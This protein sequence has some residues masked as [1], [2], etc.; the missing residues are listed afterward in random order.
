M[1][2]VGAPSNAPT[3]RTWPAFSAA[4]WAGFVAGG[5]IALAALAAYRNSFAVPFIFDDIPTILRNGTIRHLG[6]LG[7][8]LS[9]P[10]DGGVGG[11]PLVNLSLALNYAGGGLAVGGYH[12][13]NLA[14]HTLAAFALFGV[15]RRTLLR[16]VL[17]A[18]FGAVAWPLA[19]AVAVL[20]A[21]HPLQ[22][23]SVTCVIQRTELLVG[24][25]YLLTFY[26]FVRAADSPRPGL[27][28]AL[29]IAAC[30]LGMASKEVMVTAPVLVF[31]YDRTF[32]AGSFRQAWQQRRSWYAGLA[33][34]WLL[35]GYLLTTTGG[36]RGSAVG[37]G[38]GVTWWEYA[39]TQCWAVVRYLQLS[40][41]P[42]PLIVDYGAAAVKQ[43]LTVWPQAVLLALLV[44]GTVVSLRRRPTLGFLG[45]W[46]FVILSPSSSVV[47]LVTQTIAEHRMYL[48]LVAVLVLTVVALFTWLGRR[49]L[50]VAA[51]L[52]VGLGVLT[53]QRNDTY[54]SWLTL[55]SDT[56]ARRPDNPRARLGLGDA[57]IKERRVPEAIVQYEEA[58]RLM[59]DYT[60]AH[61]NLGATLLQAGRVPEAMGQFAAALRIAPTD[62]E[63]NYNLGAALA[64]LGR[65]P[66]AAG[67]LEQ[68]V[69]LRP[70]YAEAHNNLGNAL[71]HLGRTREAADHYEQSL[72]LKPDDVDAH[73]N[74][75]NALYALGRLPEAIDQYRQALQLAPDADACCMLGN[76]LDRIG[77]PTEAIAQYEAALRLQP[78]H[79]QA[80]ANLARLRALPQ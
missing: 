26:C 72:R 42:H 34:T 36:N 4:R 57:L 56:V 29:T 68:A 16:P 78:D 25:F 11:R 37:F 7:A 12:A 64:R 49:S 3:E 52:A 45:A 27:W 19:L 65:M 17:R 15:V 35:L 40:F 80:R 76:A 44:A 61:N 55:W 43:V 2:A 50:L 73:Y 75:G 62:A 24:L 32:V 31:L 33:A 63:A 10:S 79:A 21:V 6:S 14:L 41:W 66:E 46:F 69:R 20:W 5:I 53:V 47:P 1:A 67:Y 60:Q 54:R 58:L 28:R 38:L 70:D 9:P 71:L 59:P 39:L 48:P 74:L 18:R 13:T 8:V 22:T 51:A 30:L 23:E 77:R